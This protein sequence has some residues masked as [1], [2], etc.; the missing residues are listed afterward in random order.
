M[1]SAEVREGRRK[2]QKKNGVYESWWLAERGRKRG[3]VLT[4]KII[5]NGRLIKDIL[6]CYVRRDSHVA[7]VD[8]EARKDI[9]K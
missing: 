6:R 1:G 2:V 3:T 8:D 4:E 9:M 5:W 7:R